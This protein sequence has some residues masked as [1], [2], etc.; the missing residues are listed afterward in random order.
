MA[1]DRRAFLRGSAACAAAAAVPLPAIAIEAPV[2]VSVDGGLFY[3]VTS[4]YQG[5][6]IREVAS[7]DL[8]ASDMT[9]RRV[10]CG[11]FMDDSDF[12]GDDDGRA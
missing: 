11:P 4:I 8:P 10:Y 5:V 7:I 6:P 2:V 12:Y 9:W 1:I 3:G